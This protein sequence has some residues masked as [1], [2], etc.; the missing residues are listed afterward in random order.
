YGSATFNTA[1]L[2]RDSD[3]ASRYFIISLTKNHS[4]CQNA[5]AATYLLFYPE[6]SP[7]FTV[8]QYGENGVSHSRQ[9]PIS[10]NNNDRDA[11]H[12]LYVI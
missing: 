1:G 10:F 9:I 5:S 11:G 7:V 12:F 6:N 2:H 4:A 3:L 8:I